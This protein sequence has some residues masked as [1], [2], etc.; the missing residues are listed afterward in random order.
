MRHALFFPPFDALANPRLVADLA[1]DAE[2]AGWDG[3]F[4]WDHL[5]Y[6]E[7]VEQIL[8]P[9]ICLAAVAM[10][11]ERILLGP[12]VTPLAR[13]R[14][15]VVARQ[16]VT[17]D[18]LSRGRLVLGFGLGDD[19]RTR[20]MSRFGEESDPAARAALLD[21]H[22]EVLTGLL[23][24]R[25][26]EHAGPHYRAE[27]VTFQPTPYR[28]EGIPIWMAARWPNRA[29][30]RRAARYD[31]LFVIQC[32]EPAQL[33][34]VRS[35]LDEAGTAESFELVANGG[36]DIDPGPWAQ[37]GATWWLTQLGPYRL[38][39]AE[40]RRVVSAGPRAVSTPTGSVG[41]SSTSRSTT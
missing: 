40:V 26:V 12:M 32:E 27:G 14:P 5:I 28:P 31:G 1:A 38:D 6:S 17:L 13:R 4:L 8:D 36:P 3:V 7:P 33:E 10:S 20:E 21:E 24:G 19:W 34:E 18:H 15:A 37:A 25:P 39:L 41:P 9:W 22:L 23:S 35:W 2:A 16:A 29:P 11:T 30:V